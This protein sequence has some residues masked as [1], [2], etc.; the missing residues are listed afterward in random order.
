V[1]IVRDLRLD[2][3]GGL[4][5]LLILLDRIPSYVVS[6]VTVRNLRIQ[7]CDRDLHFHF[8]L[9]QRLSMVR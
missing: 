2:L 6:W 3:F 5:L 9:R 8:R 7:R 4:A 1:R